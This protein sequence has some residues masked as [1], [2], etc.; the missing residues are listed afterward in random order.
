MRDFQLYRVPMN[1]AQKLPR[2]VVLK[3]GRSLDTLLDARDLIAAFPLPRQRDA[4]WETAAD[5]LY[6]AA[7][8]SDDAAVRAFAVQLR[9]ALNAEKLI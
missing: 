7:H 9:L 3:D 4:L 2:P 6:D 8:K 5:L 1:W